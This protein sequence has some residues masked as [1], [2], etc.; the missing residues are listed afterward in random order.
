M[1]SLINLLR[2]PEI[3]NLDLNN[4]K[5]LIFH[6]RILSQKSLLR[7]V[8]NKFHETFNSCDKI[9]FS[10]TGLRIELGSGI[11]P[12][13]DRYS[14]VL[15]TDVVMS[16]GLD[17]VLDAHDMNL[18]SNSVRALFGQ[19]CF[20]HFSNPIKFFREAER[21]LEPGGGIVLIEPYYG[22]FAEF[23]YPKLFN[24]EGYDKNFFSWEAPINGPMKGAN[25]ALSYIVFKRDSSVF[26]KKFPN[27]KI[28]HQSTCNNYLTYLLSGGLNFKQMVPNS[29]A[30]IIEGLEW[31]ISPLS[32]FLALHHV[33]VIR[34]TL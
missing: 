17:Q 33:I 12:I 15:A 9:F 26:E 6:R 21:V 14:D 1:K 24:S 16:S 34:K 32:R 11:A 13:R 23:L 5:R 29:F 2:Y 30:P 4:E 18:K 28:I 10:G 19:N 8:F 7:K 27:L 22:L 25:Q 3:N 31:F 20:H